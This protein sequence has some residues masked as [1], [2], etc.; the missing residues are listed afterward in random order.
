MPPD[1]RDA[2]LLW[3]MLRHAR[4]VRE[5]AGGRTLADYESDDVLRLAI[6]RLVQIVGEAACRL[7]KP[8]RDAHPQIPWPA[9]MAQRHVLVHGYGVIINKKIWDVATI[10]IPELIRLLEQLP[11]PPADPVPE[12]PRDIIPP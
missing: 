2:A 5:L 4:K 10:H 1:E 11:P 7:T 6:E 9:I 3:D 12:D 8:C